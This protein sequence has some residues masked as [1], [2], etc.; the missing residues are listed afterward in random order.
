MIKLAVIRIENRN[1]KLIEKKTIT[2]K[3]TYKIGDNKKNNTSY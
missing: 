2:K 3:L 1:R